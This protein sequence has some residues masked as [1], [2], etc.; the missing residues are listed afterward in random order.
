MPSLEAKLGLQMGQV[1]Q[2]HKHP[3]GVLQPAAVPYFQRDLLARFVFP[4]WHAQRLY[5]S[6]KVRLDAISGEAYLL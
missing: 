1:L 4:C 2:S 6:T 3:L 5:E